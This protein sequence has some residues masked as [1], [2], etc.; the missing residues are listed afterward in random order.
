[1]TADHERSVV[2]VNERQ[3][4]SAFGAS[5]TWRRNARGTDSDGWTARFGERQ[6]NVVVGHTNGKGCWP[7]GEVPEPWVSRQETPCAIRPWCPVRKS[8]Y[9][10]PWINKKKE[11][12]RPAGRPAI[13]PPVVLYSLLY[14]LLRLL[15][16]I[17]IVRGRGDAQLR[18]EVL[19][20]R[21]QLGVLE[22]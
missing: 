15:I 19:A 11:S 17:L 21:H 9:R 12:Q 20:L 7:K 10:L 16:E 8:P 18:A 5:R 6:Q 13:P 1:M 14:D 2:S 22:R 4:A 3:P